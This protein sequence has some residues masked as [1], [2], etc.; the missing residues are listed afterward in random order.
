MLMDDVIV[1]PSMRL[2]LNDLIIK[3]HCDLLEILR[4]TDSM[5]Q[6]HNSIQNCHILFLLFLSLLL[7]ACN[8]LRHGK[9]IA[10]MVKNL[11][12]MQET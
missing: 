7:I 4:T 10:Q 9:T 3:S 12:A 5:I 1:I 11:P 6:K 2:F 8:I